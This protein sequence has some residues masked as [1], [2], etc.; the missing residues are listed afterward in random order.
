MPHEQPGLPRDPFNVSPQPSSRF[1]PSLPLRAGMVFG[2]NN[3]CLG[4][5]KPMTEAS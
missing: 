5:W 4:S 3:R 2:Q 1:F